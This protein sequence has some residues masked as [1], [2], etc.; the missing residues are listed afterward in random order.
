MPRPRAVAIALA[1]VVAGAALL[2]GVHVLGLDDQGAVASVMGSSL[3]N[4]TQVYD[5]TGTVLLADIQQP[6]LKHTDV[7]FSAMGRWLPEATVAVDDPGFWS[8]PGVDPGR[9]A[10]AALGSGDTGSSIALRLVRL[11][12]GGPPS[13]APARARAVALAVRIAA[14]YPRPQILA[15]YLNSL[16]YGNVSVGAEAAATTYFQVDVGQLDLAEAALI[17]GLPQAPAALDPSLHLTAARARQRQVLDAMVRSGAIRPAEADRAAAEP[18]R[19]FGPDNVFAARQFV[20]YVANALLASYGTE[21]VQHRGLTVRTTLDWGLQ[22]QAELAARRALDPARHATVAVVVAVDPRTGQILAYAQASAGDLAVNFASG[23]PRSPG[24]AFR[25]FTYAA[26]IA[27]RRYTMVTPIDDSPLTVECGSG[28]PSYSPREFDARSHGVC[29]LRDCVGNGLVVPAVEMELGL[30]VPQVVAAARAVGAPPYQ[31]HFAADGNVTYTTD[32]PPDSFGP[33]LTLGGYGET[34]LAMASGLATLADG[35]VLH[36]PESLLHV[37]PAGGGSV[38]QPRPDPGRTV[39]DPGAAFVV[40]ETL[41]D[42]ATRQQVYGVSTPLGFAGR[43]VAAVAGTAEA[44]SD[45]SAAGYTPSLAA[46]LWTGNESYSPLTLGSDGIF[47]AAPAW[48]Q[49]MQAAL[50]Q[51][52]RGDEWY[53]PPAGVTGDIVDGRQAWFLAGTSASTPAPPLPANA[54]RS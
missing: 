21:A 12:L 14:T 29:A 33:S 15:R 47:A 6:N 20:D 45:A 41:A 39:I 31:P 42:A 25:V 27:S 24:T 30:G 16:Y 10:G 40:S 35:G 4:D 34:P 7:P 32:A 23:P 46:A 38:A 18:L 50:D 26:A 54:H 37:T 48:H 3:P 19:V 49:F 52:G 53:Q 43:H 36:A 51:L 44:F 17:A 11:R 5:R 13:G 22:Q 1:V 8:E 28:C 2:T 9:L